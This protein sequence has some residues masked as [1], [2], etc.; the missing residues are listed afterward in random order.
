MGTL[1]LFNTLGKKLEEFKPLN[2]P[3]VKMYSCGPT[4]YDYAHIGN[5]RTFVFQDVLRRYL[6]YKGYIVYQCCNITDVDDKT[7]RASRAEGVSLRE[8]T[9]RYEKAFFEDIDALNIER[10]EVYP[11]ATEHIQEMVELI[12]KLLEKGYAYKSGG[13]VYYDISKFKDYGKLSGISLS[14]LKVGARVKADQYSKDEV[15]DFALWKEWDFED[16]DVY[17]STE[18]GKGRPGW[19]IECSSMSMKYLG[20]SFDIHTG[21]VDLIF[22]HHE[23][24]I[25]Q[26]EAAT[27]K[28]L[29]RFWLH[30]E[31]LLVRG[32]K[33]AKSLGNYYTLRDLMN[34]GYDPKAIRF[35]LLSANYRAPLN[36]TEDGLKQA[37]RSVTR[38][39][40]FVERVR[41]TKGF[42]HRPSTMEERILEAEKGFEEAMDDDLNTP[43]ALAALFEFIRDMN[44]AIDEGKVSDGDLQKAYQLMLKL[45]KVLGII[46]TKEERLEEDVERLI[47]I[48]ED[49]RKRKDWALADKIRAELAE[50]GI[51]LEDTPQG[52]RWKRR[53]GPL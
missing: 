40:D 14:S 19:H 37:E 30:C 49:A 7:I 18:L 45:D 35:L 43:A 9:S 21:G 6:E 28:P 5:F 31:H 26:S 48:R 41:R 4:V 20:E 17:W 3:Y 47:K 15:Q 1:R 11:R 44:R 12:K 36:F 33:M 50:R 32:Q 52:V 2:P 42:E 23:N 8:Y 53:L 24:E 25:A 38:I 10:A 29:A 22:P 13:S 46:A 34:L 51:I 16:G 39:L 27:G